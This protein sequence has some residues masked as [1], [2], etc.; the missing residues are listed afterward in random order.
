[1]TA[2]HH[3]AARTFFCNQCLSYYL[4]QDPKCSEPQLQSYEK[5]NYIKDNQSQ[6]LQ[7]KK[8]QI[9]VYYPETDLVGAD[10]H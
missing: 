2:L 9:M 6:R 10:F 4:E 8:A 3:E 1:M 7:R 5:Y